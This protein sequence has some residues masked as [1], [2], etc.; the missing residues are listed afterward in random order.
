MPA[1]IA[2]PDRIAIVRR[3]SEFATFSA[4]A[5]QDL[6][7]TAQDGFDRVREG[8]WDSV[9]D[10]QVLTNELAGI[11]CVPRRHDG[12]ETDEPLRLGDDVPL[13]PKI[14]HV[15]LIDFTVRLDRTMPI[16]GLSIDLHQ[17]RNSIEAVG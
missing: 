1:Y 4:P 3:E 11:V 13:V 17:D 9:D 7:P 10:A 12:V 8:F 6:F 16:T 5:I 2:D 15:R 14:P